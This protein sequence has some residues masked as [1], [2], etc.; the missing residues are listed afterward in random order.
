MT[1]SGNAPGTLRMCC[2]NR[3]P[4]GH[5][6]V[7]TPHHPQHIPTRPHVKR[8]AITTPRAFSPE[9]RV[10]HI[11]NNPDFEDVPLPGTA[12]ILPA[13]H[14]RPVKADSWARPRCPPPT[15]HPHRF[16]SRSRWRQRPVP[17]RD[18]CE[19]CLD[20]A[21]SVPTPDNGPCEGD[22]FT[23]PGNNLRAWA[24]V[25]TANPSEDPAPTTHPRCDRGL[26]RWPE[27]DQCRGHRQTTFAPTTALQGHL[28]R[29]RA[30]YLYFLV[31]SALKR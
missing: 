11:H 21:R 25:G 27:I 18:H 10:T 3:I 26:Q 15:S 14:R 1:A 30:N 6:P 16:G 4:D 29:N 19:P 7:A 17:T 24:G 28:L 2:R 5:R 22:G 23:R 9:R 8:G 20:A 31:P 12:G 13:S